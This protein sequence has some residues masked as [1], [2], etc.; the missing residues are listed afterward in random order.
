MEN[1]LEG[2]QS[3][4]TRPWMKMIISVKVATCVLH[5]S[6]SLHQRRCHVILIGDAG[7]RSCALLAAGLLNFQVYQVASRLPS[8]SG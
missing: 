8:Q 7:S 3:G 1:Q 4:T 6:Q 5:I 2:Q